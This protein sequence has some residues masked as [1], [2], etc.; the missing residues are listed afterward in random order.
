MAGY[1]AGSVVV[2]PR[3]GVCRVVGTLPVDICA[4]SNVTV[5]G[6]HINGEY[7]KI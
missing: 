2:S 1:D 3:G 4:V 5:Y 6:Y 7:V